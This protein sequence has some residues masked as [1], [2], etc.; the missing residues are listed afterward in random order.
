MALAE[1]MKCLLDD[2]TLRVEMGRRG[3]A[4]IDT[5]FAPDAMVAGNLAVYRRVLRMAA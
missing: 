4:R 1:A 3:R 2:G 5:H